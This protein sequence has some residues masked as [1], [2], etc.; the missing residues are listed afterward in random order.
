MVNRPGAQ[1]PSVHLSGL[2]GSVLSIHTKHLLYLHACFGV[3]KYICA[4]Q[5][6]VCVNVSLCISIFIY[7]YIF[8]W[9]TVCRS[10]YMYGCVYVFTCSRA[11]LCLYVR[12][13]DI[14]NCNTVLRKDTH[15]CIHI[16][17]YTRQ[18]SIQH[19]EADRRFCRLDRSGGRAA[20]DFPLPCLLP[21]M[22]LIQHQQS[23]CAST[24]RVRCKP[25]GAQPANQPSRIQRSQPIR[26]CA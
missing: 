9:L 26:C 22:T 8:M 19:R 2:E 10:S 5:V 13:L 1:D 25:T 6:Y 7:I 4:H 11:L 23:G 15:A 21:V 24:L 12:L 14:C 16:S 18:H 17:A 20:L 3:Y